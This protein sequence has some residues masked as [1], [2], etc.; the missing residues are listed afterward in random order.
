MMKRHSWILAVLLALPAPRVAADIW[1]CMDES[2]NKRFTNVKSDAK[3]CKLLKIAP[4]NT[5]PAPKQNARTASR[6]ADFPR[7]DGDTQKLRDNDRRR[8][9]DQEFANEQKLL[10]QARIELAEQES[11]RLGN[12]RNYQR[13]LDR[14]EPYKKK[15]K[16]H[17][18]NIAN[19]KRELAD[20][21]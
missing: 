6:P 5:V 8:I 10:E 12:E 21:K 13:M 19:L 4:P 15:V 14:L 1:E 11:Q 18:G 16:L 17:E 9:L 20:T 3:G 7:V 2:G